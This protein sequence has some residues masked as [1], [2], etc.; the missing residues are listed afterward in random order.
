MCRVAS[1]WFAAAYLADEFAA[2]GCDLRT[3]NAVEI[4]IFLRYD[5]ADVKKI[6]GDA[7]SLPVEEWAK[8]VDS[9]LRSLNSTDV[10]VDQ[11]WVTLAKR[12]LEELRSG[13][14]KAVAGDVVVREVQKRFQSFPTSPRL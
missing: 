7:E 13:K 9:L 14:V 2:F 3:G 10:A 11:K 6:I 12:R 4:M 1:G 5:M 8:L